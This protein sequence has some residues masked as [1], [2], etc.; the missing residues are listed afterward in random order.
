MTLLD[1]N[2]GEAA[3]PEDPV[4]DVGLKGFVKD[5][6]EESRHRL[7]IVDFWAPWCGPCK[8]LVPMLEKAVRFHKGAVLLAKVNIDE[9]PEIAQQLRVQSV[10]TV[11]AFSQGQ[12]I[13]GFAGALPES[14]VQAWIDRLVKATGAHPPGKENGYGL[15]SALKQ[16]ADF[17]T[18]GQTDM[19]Q[20]VYADILKQEP[21]NAAAF[22]GSL[23][24]LLALGDWKMAEEILAHAP[25][26]LAKDKALDGLRAALEL[27]KQA[28]QAGDDGIFRERLANNPDDHEARFG[29]AMAAYAA[30]R[31]D[32]AVESLLEIVQRDRTW[33][34]E[35]ARKQLVKFF[36]AFGPSDPLTLSARK[37][38]SSILFS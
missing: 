38:L 28:A 37:R 31:K 13:D 5:V 9:A 25:D 16:A 36:E 33:N 32:E 30:G 20:A 27:A 7:V 4:K 15:E 23:Q 6:I 2:S 22:A 1:L 17:L 14:Q 19:A 10:P 29:L 3:P 21:K 24:C 26:D 35:A 11:F 34:E 12:P 8:Q 18:A